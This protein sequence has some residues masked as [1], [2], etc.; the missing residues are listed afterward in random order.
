MYLACDLRGQSHP[1]PSGKPEEWSFSIYLPAMTL[2][3]HTVNLGGGKMDF[4]SWAVFPVTLWVDTCQYPL[5]RFL[6]LFFV[7][8]F[9]TAPS[10]LFLFSP[11]PQTSLPPGPGSAPRPL[12]LVLPD[13]WTVVSRSVA[14][15][16]SQLGVFPTVSGSRVV[17]Y[18]HFLLW[19]CSAF[20]SLTFDKVTVLI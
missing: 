12:S 6:V 4:S 5:K 18:A 10:F 3:T 8:F 11:V 14:L 16:E 9:F 15:F 2:H 1:E 13:K 7:F 20:V 17:W 19:S